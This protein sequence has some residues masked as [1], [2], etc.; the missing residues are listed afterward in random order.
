MGERERQQ[1]G[2][3]SR[4]L[5]TS[6]VIIGQ[7][8]E[9]GLEEL[10]HKIEGAAMPFYRQPTPTNSILPAAN[11]NQR[12]FTASQRHPTPF[13]GSQRQPTPTHAVLF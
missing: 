5:A 2:G 4:Q 12:H 9:E 10:E 7:Q 1:N 13:A 3:V 6:Q 11:A 8:T